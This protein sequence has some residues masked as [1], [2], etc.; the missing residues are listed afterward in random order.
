VSDED[1][2][3]YSSLDQRLIRF[4]DAAEKEREEEHGQNGLHAK[5][6]VI[7][8]R[9]ETVA[10]GLLEHIQECHEQRKENLVTRQSVDLRLARLESDSATKPVRPSAPPLPPMRSREDSSHDLKEFAERVQKSA[11][12]GFKDPDKTPDALVREIVADEQAKRDLKRLQ[13]LEAIRA[14]EVA[15]RRKFWRTIAIAAV[16]GGGALTGLFE[17]TKGLLAHH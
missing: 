6:D 9:V 8:K 11:I 13:D 7:R 14:Q 5:L 12:E 1:I 4:I 3:K 15:D 2:T 10:D 16:S 17:A